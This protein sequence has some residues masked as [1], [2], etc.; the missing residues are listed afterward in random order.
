MT[1]E[2]M[3]SAPH[4]DRAPLSQ[5]VKDEVRRGIT[6]GAY[7]AESRVSICRLAESLA[8]SPTPVRE[9]L[10]QLVAEG[11]LDL[12]PNRGFFVRPMTLQEVSELYPVAASLEDLGIRTVPI[13]EPD[14]VAALKALNGHLLQ[15]IGGDP[16]EM[17]ILNQRW[18]ALLLA[19][20]GNRELRRFVAQLRARTFRYEFVCYSFEREELHAQADMHDLILTR[21]AAG[22][23]RKARSLMRQH[24]SE[25]LGLVVTCARKLLG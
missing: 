1:H 16:E 5:A 18:H 20:C 17:I 22:D 23:R 7:P 9:A 15:S 14:Q 24:W 13:P 21:L 3:D 11:F 19:P 6:S 4:F 10:V 12:H 25:N 8:M 2:S